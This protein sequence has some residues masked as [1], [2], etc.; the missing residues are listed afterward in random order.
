MTTVT[1]T[2][3]P[4]LPKRFLRGPLALLA[5]VRFFVPERPVG[6]RID[7]DQ[8][9]IFRGGQKSLLRNFDLAELLHPLFPLLLPLQQFALASHITAVT[10][11]NDVLAKGTHGLTG[12]HLVADGRLNNDLKHLPGDQFLE[13]RTQST[14]PLVRLFPVNDCRKGHRADRR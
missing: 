10:L 13:L 11:G 14:A 12:N 6:M 5:V 1:A 4:D 3:N 9:S 2:R 8:S 7:R